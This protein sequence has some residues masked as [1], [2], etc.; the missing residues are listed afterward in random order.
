MSADISIDV[1][2]TYRCCCTGSQNVAYDISLALVL[3]II[4]LLHHIC[5][6]SETYTVTL[7]FETPS[8]QLHQL[9]K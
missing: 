4:G 8:M 2:M 9:G 5:F 7:S 3:Q 6:I 1:L